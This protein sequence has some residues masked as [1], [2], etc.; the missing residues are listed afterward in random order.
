MS[1]AIRRRLTLK[2]TTVLIAA[3]AVGIAWARGGWD[4]MY[5]GAFPIIRLSRRLGSRT[6]ESCVLFR[7]RCRFWR[8]GRWLC[9]PSA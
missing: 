9:S 6:T 4:W 2:D 5:I 8:R 1:P 3:T 7:R